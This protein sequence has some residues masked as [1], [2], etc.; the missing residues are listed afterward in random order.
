MSDHRIPQKQSKK[1]NDTYFQTID[2]TPQT[3]S[4]LHPLFLELPFA[5]VLPGLVFFESLWS[6]PLL[7]L[8]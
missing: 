4:Y 5:L 3:A 1:G 7:V 6:V 8:S 2:Q